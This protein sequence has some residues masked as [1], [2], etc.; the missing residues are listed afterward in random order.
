M[1]LLRSQYT[2]ISEQAIWAIGN[3]AGDCSLYRD[4]ILKY[5]GLSYL[6]DIVDKSDNKNTIKH[7]TWAISNLCRG[8]PLPK[9]ESVKIAIPI[10][11][12]M[13]TVSTESEVLTDAAWALSYLSDGEEQRI[14]L[15]IDTG[16]LPH[17]LKH[18]THP[19]LSIV[20]PCLRTLGNIVTGSDV[21]T[22]TVLSMPNC[23]QTIFS[24]LNH[25]KRSVRREACWTLSNIAAGNED[26]IRQLISNKGLI[27]KLMQL[28][29]TDVQEI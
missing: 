2:E 6:I 9:F 21:Q 28:M 19:F 18:V 23:L 29:E 17:L 8:R 26:Q 24:L 10:L 13:M 1:N 25:E 12:K 20:I 27:E 22:D 3:I 11:A 14:Q 15:V 16:V 4:M 7:G 5:N